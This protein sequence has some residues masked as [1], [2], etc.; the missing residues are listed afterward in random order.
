MAR[1]RSLAHKPASG[2]VAA[3]FADKH[4]RPIE[5]KREFGTCGRA[6]V[7]PLQFLNVTSSHMTEV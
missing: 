1:E 4:L 5:L 7:A 2:N 6:E 3:V